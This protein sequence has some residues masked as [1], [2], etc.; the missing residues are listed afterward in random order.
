MKKTMFCAT[1]SIGALLFAGVAQASLIGSTVDVSAYFGNTS[2]PYY[3][4][5]NVVVGAGVEYPAGSYPSYNPSWQIDISDS[6]LTIT[7]T[8]STGFPFVTSSF[9]GW[10]LT[11]VSGPA[12]TSAAVDA[13]SDFSPFALSIV[14]G[15]L[16]LNYSGVAGPSGGTSIINFATDS[17]A[18]SVPEPGTLALLGLGLAGLGFARRR[19]LN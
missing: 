5:G 15:T 13:G 18:P 14:N 8:A 10:I 17:V 1:A 12:I 19:K 3:D 6:Q 16:Q 7:D 11:V 2:S 9:N 4:P